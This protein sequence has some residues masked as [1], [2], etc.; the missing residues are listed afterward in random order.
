MRIGALGLAWVVAL[1]VLACPTRPEKKKKIA[2]QP[3]PRVLSPAEA[4]DAH[5][6]I[7]D[8]KAD[9]SKFLEATGLGPHRFDNPGGHFRELG[10]VTIT[11][12]S[13]FYATDLEGMTDWLDDQGAVLGSTE[14]K[15]IGTIVP[16][17]KKYFTV[18]DKTMTSGRVNA[19]AN[20]ATVRITHVSLTL[21]HTAP[22][23]APR[24]L[25][26]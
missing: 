3:P 21:E 24:L 1:G 25:G 18:G 13:R 10:G 7:A 11:N 4:K 17:G 22:D 16:G 19:N 12:H 2:P 8:L 6:E 23:Q 20:H 14:L 5:D 9:P 15:I 26:H